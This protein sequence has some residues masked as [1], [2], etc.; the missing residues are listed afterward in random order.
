MIRMTKISSGADAAKYFDSALNEREDGQHLQG[1]DNYYVGENSK[2]IWGG[3]IAQTL[4]LDGQDVTRQDFIDLMDGKLTNPDTGIAQ[5]LSTNS[6]QRRAGYDLTW[7]APKSVSIAALVHGDERLIEAFKASVESAMGM[8]QDY[9]AQYRERNGGAPETFKSDSLIW[10]SVQHETSRDGDAQLHIHSVT[11]SVTMDGEGKF[12]SL[13]NTEIIKGKTYLDAA[14]FQNRDF[15]R[16]CNELG[17]E[18]TRDA[19]GNFELNIISKESIKEQSKRSEAIRK[20]LEEKGINPKAATYEQR[21][22]AAINTRQ[23]KVE[24]SREES[25]NGWRSQA[26]PQRFA[27]EKAAVEKAREGGITQSYISQTDLDKSIAK[28]IAHLSE[29]EFSFREIHLINQVQRFS[30]GR[31]TLSQIENVIASRKESGQIV[32][33]EGPH[34]FITTKDLQALETKMIENAISSK[35]AQA[36]I[37]YNHADLEKAVEKANQKFIQSIEKA[38][39]KT[40][41]GLSQEQLSEITGILG[42]KDG[43]ALV[44]GNAGTGKTTAVQV[45][46]DL[47][48]ARNYK[49]MGIASS[50][51]ATGEIKDAGIDDS[52]NIAKFFADLNSV[53]R[54]LDWQIEAAKAKTTSLYNGMIQIDANVRTLGAGIV[55]DTYLVNLK[56]MSV[57]RA[58][59]G[60]L[61]PIQ[62]AASDSKDLMNKLTG[63]AK[64][65]FRKEESPIG[66]AGAILGYAAARIGA[67]VAK[68]GIEHEKI[69]G[70]GVEHAAVVALALGKI[71]GEKI[72][73]LK[74]VKNLESKKA[75]FERTGNVEGK[76]Q[77]LIVDE[78]SMVGTREMAKIIDY[79]RNTNTR[80]VIQ[81]D[82]K[83]FGSV[84]GGRAFEQLKEAGLLK[85]ELAEA[86]RFKTEQTRNINKA[87]NNGN[88][89]KAVE[90]STIKEVGI[91]NKLDQKYSKIAND[92]QLYKAAAKE[93]LEQSVS[94]KS[95]AVITITNIDRKAVNAE[96]RKELKSSGQLDAKEFEFTNQQAAKLSDTE[97][98]NV[99]ILKEKGVDTLQAN[100]N[101]SLSGLGGKPDFVKGEQLQV[102]EYLPD[103]NEI[104]VL[105]QNGY[106]VIINPETTKGFD[107]ISRNE[108][109]SFANGDLVD[110]RAIIGNEY[111]L[112]K[113]GRAERDALGNKIVN[114]DYISTGET[115]K[116]LE[117]NKSGAKIEFSQGN[118]TKTITLNQEQMANIDHAYARTN[119][120]TQGRT[121]DIAIAVIGESGTK[122]TEK[123]GVYV[124]MTRA[125]DS[126]TVLTTDK[127]ALLRN[128]N[129]ISEKTTALDAPRVEQGI[130]PQ[131]VKTIDSKKQQVEKSL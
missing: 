60:V 120:G 84:S 89:E 23:A 20:Y 105:T 73:I 42:T 119:F 90:L 74:E 111:K 31:A 91:S 102:L 30:D 54:Q 39:G 121:V 92:Q 86:T 52:K 113:Y 26:D 5:D 103:Q 63:D 67:N 11:A 97:K 47:A 117:V 6:Q 19:K 93:Y 53:P 64:T 81:G 49:V 66:K 99:L 27:K 28:A 83:Q 127:D 108:S 38:T 62:N 14:E 9:G 18:T 115:G 112:D 107:P 32:A 125:R 43:I 44:Q 55:K 96:I 61:T 1:A 29:N 124:A 35:G 16:R 57:Y 95:I 46:K 72:E 82:G 85:F 45:I 65:M 58:P 109:R 116:V 51:K 4:G 126:V 10:A 36:P 68:L 106:T 12:H 37:Y 129:R 41:S 48:E 87:L 98:T 15:E 22:A 71:A 77:V 3:R 34:S 33:H 70:G 122:M 101:I 79:S 94:G 78:A 110:A 104:K 59:K 114:P 50:S 17:Y 88:Y 100:Q 13:T 7:S 25:I 69:N 8:N 123:S 56:D 75:N 21:Q 130:R 80:L 128:A 2:A 131:P 40:T 118:K 24:I 76:S